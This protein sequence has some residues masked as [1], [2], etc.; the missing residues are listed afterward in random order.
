MLAKFCRELEFPNLNKNMIRILGSK[1]AIFQ[2][3]LISTTFL[4]ATTALNT[5]LMALFPELPR[6][7]GTRNRKVKPLQP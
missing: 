6:W 3:I 4:F 2:L 1:I 5:R 7:A